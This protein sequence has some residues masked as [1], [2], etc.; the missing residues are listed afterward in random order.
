MRPSQRLSISSQPLGGFS[1][2]WSVLL[3]RPGRWRSAGSLDGLFW[4]VRGPTSPAKVETRSGPVLPL[5]RFVGL[6]NSPWDDGAVF[7]GIN[8]LPMP[9][10][11]V[12][13]YGGKQEH[14]AGDWVFVYHL[15]ELYAGQLVLREFG[16]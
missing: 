9:S 5:P 6:E 1:G 8:R 7:G 3:E 14:T 10:L 13:W 15:G 16:M 11:G 4:G 2:L 12:G